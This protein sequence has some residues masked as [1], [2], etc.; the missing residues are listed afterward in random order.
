[1]DSIWGNIDLGEYPTLNENIDRDIIVVGGGIAGLMTAYRLTS[2]GHK[3]TLLEADKLVNKT[4]YHTTACITALQEYVYQEITDKYNLLFAQL[5]YQSQI[6]GI[7]RYGDLIHT[8]KIDCDFK[9]VPGY[10]FTHNHIDLL[11]KEHDTLMRIGSTAELDTK[12]ENFK[13]PNIKL[14]NQAIFNPIKFLA[15]LPKEF[16]IYENTRVIEYDFDNMILKTDKNTITA[17]KIILATNFPTIRTIGMF[18]FK[19]YKSDSYNLVLENATLDG[20]YNDDLGDGIT[21]RPYEDKVLFGGYD[22]RT[23]ITKNDGIYEDL[24]NNAKEFFPECKAVHK[25][26]SNDCVTFDGFPFAGELLPNVY[27]VT[28]FNKWGMA[29]SM[30][31]SV[32]IDDLINNRENKY[33]KLFS[34]SRKYI[35]SNLQDFLLNGLKNAYFL[36]K[37]LFHL[38][39]NSWKSLDNGDAGIVWLNMRRKAIYR[40][41]EG[42]YHICQSKCPHYKCELIWNNSD[43]SWDCPCHGSR[44]TIDGILL[45]SPANC[46]LEYNCHKEN[47]DK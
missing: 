11:S 24:Y 19:M 22:H 18:P 2:G 16:E 1:M 4:T 5:Y 25:C 9:E 28:G 7:R 45:T 32:V 30:I 31:C 42:N 40:D 35:S 20:I 23:G 13:Y 26:S 12:C 17:K 14:D 34:L 10:L 21:M 38:P 33:I 36:T 41:M 39:L 27:A 47:A 37:S 46:N 3:V 29:N 44:F 43:K 15:A 8:L 6:D